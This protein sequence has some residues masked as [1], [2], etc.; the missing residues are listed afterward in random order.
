MSREAKVRMLRLYGIPEPGI[1]DFLAQDIHRLINSRSGPETR[2]RFASMRP[3]NC[4]T[5]S[6]V[7]MAAVLPREFQP[8]GSGLPH[9][10]LSNSAPGNDQVRWPQ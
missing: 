6:W 2:T 3:S 7:R 4:C 8:R 1:L 5:S 10:Q 9:P